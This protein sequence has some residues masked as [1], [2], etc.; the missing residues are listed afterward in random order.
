MQ[1]T[2]LAPEV[3]EKE[4]MIASPVKDVVIPKKTEES[5]TEDDETPNYDDKYKK[6]KSKMHSDDFDINVGKVIDTLK[7]DYPVLF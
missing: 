1:S 5:E 3:K 2:V 7:N 6:K 4:K